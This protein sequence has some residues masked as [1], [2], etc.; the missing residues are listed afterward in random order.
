MSFEIIDFHIHPF[1]SDGDNINI[2]KEAMD[3]SHLGIADDLLRAG[4]SAFCGAVTKHGCD[5]SAIYEG[6]RDALR[7]REIYGEKYIPGFQINPNFVEESLKEVDFAA[8]NGVKLIGELVPYI[9]GW[10]DYAND[11][12]SIILD[13]IAKYNMIVSLHTQGL[14]RMEIMA[15]KHPDITFVFAH[16]GERNIL[17]Q[18]IDVMKKCDN[19][20]LDLSG[21]GVFRLGTVKKLVSEVG[22]ERILFGTDYPI[23]NPGVYVGGVMYEKILDREKELIFSANAK[24]LLNIQ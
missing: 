7:L 23:C 13:H 19:V 4:I 2:Y 10:E 24:R 22:A 3:F 9:H 20:Y 15:K 8:E 5:F 11:N 18:H 6:N 17:L 21:T 12:F 14:D 16:P 1:I